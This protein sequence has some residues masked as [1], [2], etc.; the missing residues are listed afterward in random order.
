MTRYRAYVEAIQ[1]IGTNVI[2]MR[3]FVRANSD[4]ID[5]AVIEG[6]TLRLTS[7]TGG[8]VPGE[9]VVAQVND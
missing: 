4:S 5:G 7:T 8:I 2:E 9:A 3:Q 6:A 1:W